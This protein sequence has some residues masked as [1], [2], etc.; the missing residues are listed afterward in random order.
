MIKDVIVTVNN[1]P[2]LKDRVYFE[3]AK[4]ISKLSRNCGNKVGAVIIDNKGKVISTGYNGPPSSFDD[5]IIDFTSGKSVNLKVNIDVLCNTNNFEKLFTEDEY[6]DLPIVDRMGFPCLEYEFNK[7][8]FMLHAEMNAILTVDDRARLE[9]ATIYVTHVPC[10]VCAKLIAQ[11][12]ITTVKTL[13]N[14]AKSFKDFIFKSLAIFQIS[15]IKFKVFTEE[16]LNLEE[17]K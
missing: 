12:G 15:D 14:K 5:D 9:G 1:R 6:K 7:T 10:D 16:E 17:T 3:M 8:P 4:T 2:Y 13:N 11:T